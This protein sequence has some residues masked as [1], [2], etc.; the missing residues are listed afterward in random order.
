M[1][2]LFVIW[3]R[4][5]KTQHVIAL[6]ANEALKIA[7]ETGHI[8]RPNMYRKYQDVTEEMLEQDV[9]LKQALEASISGMAQNIEDDGWY[10]GNVRVG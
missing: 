6:D 4:G 8:R 5:Y 10:I 2:R 3:N 7:A 9:K 1:R